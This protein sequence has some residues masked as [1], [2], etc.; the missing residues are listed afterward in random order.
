MK[1]KKDKKDSLGKTFLSSF[2]SAAGKS[3][4]RTIAIGC[5][6]LLIIVMMP[7]IV[8]V[9]SPNQHSLTSN[10]GL[11]N[12][13]KKSELTLYRSSYHGVAEYRSEENIE[14]NKE[15]PDFYVYYEAS[16]QAGIDFSKVTVAKDGDN[17]Y[18]VKLPEPTVTETEILQEKTEY[19]F[20][21]ESQNKLGIS[22]PALQACEADLLEETKDNNAIIENAKANAQNTI[23]ALISPFLKAENSNYELKFIF[24]GASNE[25]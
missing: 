23:R 19:I 22:G 11:E 4:W 18:V 9:V 2:V 16:I 5:I 21:D 7:T 13:I 17:V 14:K 6:V 10:A 8:S 15:E 25:Q 12:I 24:G 1:E 3:I 20:I